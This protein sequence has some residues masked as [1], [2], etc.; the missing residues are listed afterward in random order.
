MSDFAVIDLASQAEAVAAHVRGWSKAEVLA[1]LGEFGEVLPVLEAD[2]W[3]NFVPTPTHPPDEQYLLV[4][5]CGLWTSFSFTYDGLF[6]ISNGWFQGRVRS[7]SV[8][9]REHT[10]EAAPR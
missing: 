7:L 10:N 8:P 5:W 6:V 1:W 9:L 2:P 4:A 3:P